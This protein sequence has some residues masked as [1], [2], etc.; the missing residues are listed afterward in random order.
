MSHYYVTI[1]SYQ[2]RE[3]REIFNGYIEKLSAIPGCEAEALLVRVSVKGI[4]ERHMGPHL[5]GIG[6]HTYACD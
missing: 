2:V 6:A 1:T 4:P 3:L 5:K